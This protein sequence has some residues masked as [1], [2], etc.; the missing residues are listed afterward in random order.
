[1][2]VD[3]QILEGVRAIPRTYERER[4]TKVG[5]RATVVAEEAGVPSRRS[6]DQDQELR[7]FYTRKTNPRR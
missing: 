4:G 6:R 2:E 5:S 1:V 7:E 3:R